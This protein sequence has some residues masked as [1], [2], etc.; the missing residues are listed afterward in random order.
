MSVVGMDF[1]IRQIWVQTLH[2]LLTTYLISHQLLFSL[3]LTQFLTWNV[4]GSGFCH[5]PRK[6]KLNCFILFW[7]KW[8]RHS[9][10]FSLPW[11]SFIVKTQ[12]SPNGLTE[13][14]LSFSFD[15]AFAQTLLEFGTPEICFW[16]VACARWRDQCQRCPKHISW[17]GCKMGTEIP[18]APTARTRGFGNSWDPQKILKLNEQNQFDLKFC[19]CKV[20]NTPATRVACVPWNLALK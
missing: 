5:A 11:Q 15:F 20:G 17:M 1:G 13:C 4:R 3:C 14:C 6:W 8:Q 10:V 16:A 19:M 18:S 12:L 7:L 2:Q 9:L